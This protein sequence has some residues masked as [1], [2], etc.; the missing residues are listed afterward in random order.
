MSKEAYCTS[1]ERFNASYGNWEPA[2]YEDYIVCDC[3]GENDADYDDSDRPSTSFEAYA[4]P[5][6]E[7]YH[8]CEDCIAD[9]LD[10]EGNDLDYECPVCNRQLTKESFAD[11]V[12]NKHLTLEGV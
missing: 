4:I 7:D 2:E 1:R 9:F 3:C 6:K 12:L 5:W 8:I 11:H 10:D